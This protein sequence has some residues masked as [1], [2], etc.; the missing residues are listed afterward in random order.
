MDKIILKKQVVEEISA[1]IH[2][3]TTLQRISSTFH[4]ILFQLNSTTLKFKFI[5]ILLKH[6]SRL[7]ELEFME[8]SEI[9]N[10]DDFYSTDEQGNIHVQDQ[11]GYFIM[12][13]VAIND[14]K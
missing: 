4:S 12:Y 10:H 6:F 1:T 7:S 8:F 11:R 3:C 14:L 2:T 9:E 5:E 13:D